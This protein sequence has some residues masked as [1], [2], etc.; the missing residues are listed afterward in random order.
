MQG[1][2]DTVLTFLKRAKT[3][4]KVQAFQMT[5]QQES[6]D[7][8]KCGMKPITSVTIGFPTVSEN[9]VREGKNGGPITEEQNTDYAADH[10]I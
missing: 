7:I 5:L 3:E 6:S 10:A 4:G 2:D 1:S 8:Q 9:V